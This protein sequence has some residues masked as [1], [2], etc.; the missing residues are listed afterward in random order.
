MKP[1]SLPDDKQHGEFLETPVVFF[2]FRRPDTTARVFEKIREARPK[3]LYVVADGARKDK[4]DEADLVARTREVVANVDWPCEVS[5]I[6]SSVNLGLRER[7]FSG[8][9]E[10]FSK[11]PMAIVLEDD[12]LPSPSF[13]SF[14]SETLTTYENNQ[15]VALVSG[16]NFAPLKTA[17]EDY[18]FSRSTYIWG[19]GTWARTWRE[20]RSAPQVE[21]WSRQETDSIK[22]TFASKIQSKEFMGMMAIA[23]TL[24][25]WDISLAVW[26]RQQGKLTVVP[27]LNLIENIGFGSGATHTKFEAFDV[28]IPT[29]NFS[30]A[31]R[32]PSNFMP[33]EK[34]ECR[35]WREKSLRWVS[36]PFQHPIRFWALVLSYLKNR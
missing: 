24:N 17:E 14:C 25:T 8:L 3:K 27:A 7:I 21:A 2:I 13:F 15:Q 6:Y 10:V 29:S 12:C 4:I 32:H 9:D 1:D 11:E 19:W 5:R 18:F 28:Q 31:L 36:F 20:F 34:L 26:V 30:G 35:M 16:F 23:N 33:N 22:G